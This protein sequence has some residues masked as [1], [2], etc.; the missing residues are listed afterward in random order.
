MQIWIIMNPSWQMFL[1]WVT[2]TCI[3]NPG[4]CGILRNNFPSCPWINLQ[5][6]YKGTFV[7]IIYS[8]VFRQRWHGEYHRAS[9][10]P[11]KSDNNKI[12]SLISFFGVIILYP[13]SIPWA[14]EFTNNFHKTFQLSI[15]MYGPIPTCMVKCSVK[16]ARIQKFGCLN[17][18][19][20]LKLN[21][22]VGGI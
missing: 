11:G 5:L 14:L 3:V 22:G 15:Y 12:C 10:Y 21:F 20:S 1:I 19:L 9:T 17:P 7:Y 2:S 4:N 16:F 8:I 6:S 13:K 18:R